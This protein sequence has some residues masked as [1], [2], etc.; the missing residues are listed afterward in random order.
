M[1]GTEF[2]SFRYQRMTL[3]VTGAILTLA[4]TGCERPLDHAYG[5]RNQIVIFADEANWELY[6]ERL[7][8]IF[9]REIRT[10]RTEYVFQT[11]NETLDKWQFF[12]RYY[13]LLLCVA[14]S[15]DTPTADR[16]REHLSDEVEQQIA[17]ERSGRA[18]VMRNP[19]ADG[20]MLMIITADTVERLQAYLR[21]AEEHVFSLM[22][23]HLD[24]LISTLIYREDEQYDIEGQLLDDYGFTLRVPWGFRMNTDFADENFIRMIKYRLERWFFAYWIPGDEIDE[25]G[26][27][28][29]RALEDLGAR[30]ERNEEIDLGAVDFI[31]QQAMS[32]R[33]HIGRLYYDRDAVT[34]DKTFATLV[35][36]EGR[37]A[38]RLSGLWENSEKLAGGPFV[39]YCF[40][41]SDTD[42]LWWLD[43]AVFAPNVPKETQ[44]RQMDVMMHTFLTG[45]Q[46]VTYVDSIRE[47]IGDRH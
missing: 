6:G 40:H 19:Y 44:V 31:S 17:E 20:Q 26:F 22:E 39:A 38:V 4:V 46:A 15:E 47:L 36:F 42:R 12:S 2:H 13:H 25:R 35:E 1:G 16:I 8:M 32:L 18:I 30:I 43:G 5:D 10:P 9:E 23:E 37:W 33:D 41:D 14:I 45:S 7:K 11:R 3:L 28:W 29:V 27:A 21:Q 34:R 24:E